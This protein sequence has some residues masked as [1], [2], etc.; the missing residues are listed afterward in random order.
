MSSCVP[1]GVRARCTAA[2]LVSC[3]GH[4]ERSIPRPVS[5][6]RI[7]IPRIDA[8]LPWCTGVRYAGAGSDLIYV[9]RIAMGFALGSA[10]PYIPCI[11]TGLAWGLA[12]PGARQAVASPAIFFIPRIF[13]GSAFLPLPHMS[14]HH[15]GLCPP[16]PSV[17]DLSVSGE[18]WEA[19]PLRGGGRAG[20][21]KKQKTTG[22]PGARHENPKKPTWP[23]GPLGLRN[24]PKTQPR[25]PA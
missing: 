15:P 4:A 7:G 10:P 5:T 19:R 25:V 21:N 24:Q 11:A 16:G 2:A 13:A 12:L 14:M 3:V 17:F 8:G 23:R 22:G 18:K 9:P 1:C 20:E 6:P